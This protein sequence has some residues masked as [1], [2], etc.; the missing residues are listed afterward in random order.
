MERGEKKEGKRGKKKKKEG[1]IQNL[2]VAGQRLRNPTLTPPIQLSTSPKHE[3]R[4]Y[5]YGH[6]ARAFLPG[7]TKH[8]SSLPALKQSAQRLRARGLLSRPLSADLLRR[9]VALSSGSVNAAAPIV[10]PATERG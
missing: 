7:H 1:R 8:S 2:L 4:N 6:L 5:T 10:C 3:K 9:F